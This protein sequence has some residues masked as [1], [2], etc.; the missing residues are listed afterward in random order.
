M[1][2]M[3]VLFLMLVVLCMQ[4]RAGSNECDQATPINDRASSITRT[5]IS[6]GCYGCY[7]T[8]VSTDLDTV[9]KDYYKNINN[10]WQS[11]K[12][13]VY[14]PDEC[15]EPQGGGFHDTPFKRF[16]DIARRQ[17]QYVE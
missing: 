16:L 1:N 3:S 12:C 13:C 9:C 6:N 7:S 11:Y 2:G 15:P 10:V 8:H 4:A 17:Q 5:C 14:T